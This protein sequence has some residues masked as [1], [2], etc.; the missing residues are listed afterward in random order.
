MVCFLERD[1][2]NNWFLAA[3]IMSSITVL[4]HVFPG[5]R[6]IA[7]P[8]LASSELKTVPKYA[9]YYCWHLVSITL[10]GIAVAF[11]FA[12]VDQSEAL[13]GVFATVGAGSFAI[14][15]LLLI[16]IFKLKIWQFP[17]WVLFFPAAFLGVAGILN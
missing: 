5:G 4:V 17:Q 10:V 13:L 11:Y 1:D 2:M 6:E 9:A 3:S 8:L 15:S 12:A 14:W 16:A 7:K